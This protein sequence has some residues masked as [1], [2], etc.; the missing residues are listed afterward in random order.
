MFRRSSTLKIAWPLNPTCRRDSSICINIWKIN[1]IWA[2]TKLGPFQGHKWR[3]GSFSAFQSNKISSPP[4]FI[5][6]TRSHQEVARLSN[7]SSAEPRI[8]G[9]LFW[10]AFD[11][12]SQDTCLLHKKFP[13]GK[14]FLGCDII[15]RLKDRGSLSHLYVFVSLYFRWALPAFSV[16]R[17][18]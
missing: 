11:R 4:G 10:Y 16:W 3:G 9:V 14:I 8:D 18:L 13:N 2:N 7:R 17:E 1:S 15:K 5:A 6:S 12:A